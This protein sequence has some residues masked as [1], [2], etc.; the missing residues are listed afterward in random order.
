EYTA[1]AGRF[2]AIVKQARLPLLWVGTPS[3]KPSGMNADMLAFNDIY[4]AAAEAVGGEFIDI[5]E[6]FVDDNGAFTT[7]GPDMNGQR[8]RLRGS[9]GINLTAAGKRKVAF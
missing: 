7:L 6:G 8:V 3:F 5:W 4:R 9:D 1:R 2:A